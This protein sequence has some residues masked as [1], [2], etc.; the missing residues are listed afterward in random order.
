MNSDENI[1]S[2]NECILISED[3]KQF[4]IDRRLLRKIGLFTFMADEVDV[5]VFPV[6]AVTSNILARVIEYLNLH[7][8]DDE[9]TSGYVA[10]SDIQSPMD[11]AFF[12]SLD[13]NT[14]IELTKAA[15]YLNM[16]AFLEE[17]CKAVA[18][19]MRGLST[20][21]LRQ[22]FNIV[23]DFTPEEEEQLRRETAWCFD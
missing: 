16:E 3:G 8:E 18:G 22:K 11:R 12:N 23:N 21:Q 15:N 4:T 13:L 14:L 5:S 2:S 6:H 10:Y 19:H 7:R 17:C 20:E 9:D 1:D